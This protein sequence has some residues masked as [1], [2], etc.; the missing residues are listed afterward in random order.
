MD[1]NKSILFSLFFL[2]AIFISCGKDESGD[3][4]VSREKLDLTFITYII[5][6]N[7]LSGNAWSNINA[8][9]RGIEDMD[10]D[11]NVVVFVDDRTSVPKLINMRRLPDGNVYQELLE[12]FEETNV[13]DPDFMSN[14]L[15]RVKTLFPSKS[16]ALDLWSHGMAW[17]PQNSPNKI[18]SKWFGEDSGEFMDIKQL[19]EALLNS[20]I[21]FDFILFDACLMASVEVVYE[22]RNRADFIIASPIEVWE[23][24]FPYK[25]I[26]KAM[27]C[28]DPHIKIAEAYS[29][30]YNG[31]Y[32]QN[33]GIDMTGAI[34]VIDCS[35]LDYLASATKLLFAENNVDFD[36]SI[37]NTVIRFD[38]FRYHFVYDIGD[39][40]DK[41]FGKDMTIEW[42][43]ALNKVL[44]Y[45]YSTPRFG[46]SWGGFLDL[47]PDF[48]TGLG[49]YIPRENYNYWNEYYKTLE[50]FED[51][52]Y[53]P[54]F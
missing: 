46:D 36:S 7:S 22:L 12:E 51:T 41:L 50:W 19:D 11:I 21:H 25:N 52:D 39:Y 16:Y 49:I 31:E 43:K 29:E 20:G 40:M 45:S 18:S 1:K 32:S 6:D 26:M 53:L 2:L 5:A 44:N 28:E 35:H 27:E 15:I 38:R 30:Y 33:Y 8:I 14:L 17:I 24:G 54:I 10:K 37:A 34:S 23:M 3:A 48:Y 47:N 9:E 13:V 4:V 42:H